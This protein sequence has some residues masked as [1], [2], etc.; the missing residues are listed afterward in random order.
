MARRI[1][2]SFPACDAAAEVDL[3]EDVAPRTSSAIWDALP[4][5]ATAHH[6]VYSGSEGV[7]LLPQL[8]TPPPENATADVSAGDV[9]FTWFAPGD[10]YG[11]ETAFA[12]IC[13]FYD[14]DATPS[15]PEGPVPVSVFGRFVG[16]TDAFY[17]ASRRMRR[18]GVKGLTIER[19]EDGP[20]PRHAI[21]HR[22]R[23]GHA[24]APAAALLPTG[25]VAVAFTL[26][27]DSDTPDPRCLSVLC[28]SDDGGRTWSA[29]TPID[30]FAR[31]GCRVVGIAHDSAALVVALERVADAATIVLASTDDGATWTTTDRPAPATPAPGPI[32][33]VL[34]PGP[35]GAV[36]LALTDAR[37]RVYAAWDGLR[38]APVPGVCAIHATRTELR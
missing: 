24:V 12:E 35:G 1:R 4:I 25:T 9:G 13:W 21:V 28:R 34:P 18:E 3:R 27:A 10:A 16:D 30:G 15:M 23:H 5:F 7:V 6:A 36:D 31:V 22:P 33:R 14:E 38:D 32:G 17:A 26:C 8:L 20:A 37:L 29:P 11:V 2:L 19:V